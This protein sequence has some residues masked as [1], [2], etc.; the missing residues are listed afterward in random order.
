MNTK[1]DREEQRMLELLEAVGKQSNVSQRRLASNMGIA[2]GLA[3][4]Y[5]KRCIRKGFIK[6][7]E[8]PANRYLYYLTPKGFTEKSRLTAL[9]LSTSFAFY[10][11]A[12]DSCVNV[13]NKC[14]ERGWQRILLC[15]M[16][17]LAEIATLRAQEQDVHIVG[18]LDPHTE[19]R[20]FAGVSVWRSLQQADAYDG[21]VLTELNSPLLSYEQLLKEV[22]KERILIPDILRLE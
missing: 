5:L 10:R 16:S 7:S 2:L 20:R 11:R 22:D 8:A 1:A 3:N 21:C 18:I 6:I 9:Y 19:R 12:G 4:S 14:E 15:G 17:D 13:F